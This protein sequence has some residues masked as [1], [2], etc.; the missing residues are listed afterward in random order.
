MPGVDVAQ[1]A[2]PRRRARPARRSRRRCRGRCP[3]DDVVDGPGLVEHAAPVPPRAAVGRERRGG[4]QGGVQCRAPSASKMASET[5]A[6]GQRVV[7]GVA[8]DGVGR[9]AASR[10]ATKASVAAVSGGSC[11]QMQ[12]RGRRCAAGCGAAAPA[13][14]RR[15]HRGDQ[16]AR[17]GR[18]ATGTAA[19]SA[20]SCR[21]AP[22][23]QLAP[24][25]TPSRSAP[26]SSGTHRPGRPSRSEER[27]CT[28]GR[29]GPA[30]VP[31][32]PSAR[33]PG[34]P[35]AAR[36][37]QAP[38]L[39]VDQ[40]DASRRRP[41]AGRRRR[42]ARAAGPAA[43]GRR[44]SSRPTSAASGPAAGGSCRKARA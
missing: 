36:R 11:C 27:I 3:A 29:P 15:A 44:A 16:V 22:A 13:R 30:R 40:V 39:V 41:A 26:S 12:L 42:R 14:P 21:S 2:G 24:R 8:A 6:L 38:L 10:P 20:G 43:R 34:A 28:S 31:S 5:V 1:P 4:Q 32:I 37:H 7:E 19:R 35:S 33:G 23:G 18:R 17:A 9:L 25:S